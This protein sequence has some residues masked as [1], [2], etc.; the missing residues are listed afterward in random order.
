MMM[1]EVALQRLKGSAMPKRPTRDPTTTIFM[2][3][4]SP[5]SCKSCKENPTGPREI[6][7][8]S[9]FTY[10]RRWLA[11]SAHLTAMSNTPPRTIYLPSSGGYSNSRIVPE[12][13]M[14]F[15]GNDLLTF[16]YTQS[17]D[18]RRFPFRRYS[19]DEDGSLVCRTRNISREAYVYYL[20]STPG[21]I[22]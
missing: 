15:G 10:K 7:R 3:T 5:I 17:I 19:I 11:G 6:W 1:I 12:V 20:G 2:A 22:I 9:R 13:R 18:R 21:P 14:L 16:F 8:S 4:P